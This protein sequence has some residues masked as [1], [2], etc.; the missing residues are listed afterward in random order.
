MFDLLI[1]GGTLVDGTGAPAR[2]ADVGITHGQIAEVGD[3]AGAAARET[4]DATGLTVT[5]GLI[6]IHTH[7]DGQVSWD[8]DLAPSCY[9]GVTSV[10]MGNCGVGFAPARPD[11]HEWLIE[12]LEGVED[13]PGTALAEGLTWDWETFPEYLDA[14]ARRQFTLDIG[15]QVPH[16]ALRTYVMGVRGADTECE[17]TDAE[18]AEMA[19]IVR[20]AI[21]AGALGFS[22]TR[23]AIHKTLAGDQIGTLHASERELLAIAAAVGETGRG[24]LQLIS[25]LYFSTDE[26]Y[27][28]AE[29]ALVRKIAQ[30][31]GRP[32][33]IS[34]QQSVVTA[35][36][37]RW[38]F[39]QIAALRAEGLDVSAQI[40]VRAVG[41][42]AGLNASRNPFS[43]TPSYQTIAQ[44]PLAERVARMREPD[45]R[46]RMISE[47]SLDHGNPLGGITYI[48]FQQM[49]RMNET[50]DYEP[51]REASLLA[52]AERLG[53]DPVGYVYD[54]LLEDDGHMLLYIPILNFTTGD[55]REVHEMM[56]HDFVLFGLSDAGAHVGFICD[57]SFPTHALAFWP[58]GSRTGLKRSFED[59]VHG[60]SQRSARHVGWLDRGVVAPGYVADLN[61]IDR[62]ALSLQRPYLVHD[63]PAG[64]KRLMQKANG[65]RMTIKSGKVVVRD[66]TLTGERPGTLVRGERRP[67]VVREPA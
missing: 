57:A 12:L 4:I 60:Y 5:P 40:A 19:R 67:E 25:D 32:V 45:L 48:A 64:G 9:H 47:H 17:P 56:E 38:I 10:I 27:A 1:R 33:S 13:I 23:S 36:R 61:L 52:E 7:F 53:V 16:A 50:V 63:L 55:L 37:W 11:K 20:E 24:V 28:A 44:L 49:F 14:V 22:T 15:A 3:L 43:H 29:M 34:V 65:I 2:R 8:G 39:R 6:D 21:E 31:S 46:A 58:R 18:L 62:E 66:G 42:I 54:V 59:M 30:V 26:A 51:P 35:D 41:S